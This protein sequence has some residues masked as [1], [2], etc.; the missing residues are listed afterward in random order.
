MVDAQVGGAELKRFVELL[1]E[2]GATVEELVA[3]VEVD[4]SRCVSCG[5]CVTLCPTGALGF[6]S[7]WELRLDGELCIGCGKCVPACP[8]RAITPL[9]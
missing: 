7:T 3:A 1:R 8:L 5:A 9:Q 2:G 4:G 6:S